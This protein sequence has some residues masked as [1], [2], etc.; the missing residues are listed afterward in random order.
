RFSKEF[1]EPGN[2]LDFTSALYLGL[3]H[4][5]WCLP[6]WKKLTLGKPAALQGPPGAREVERALSMLVGCDEVLL[7]PSTL[8]L[9]W[10][11]FGSLAQKGTAIF[12]DSGSY[13]IARWGVDRAAACGVPVHLFR[14]HDPGALRALLCSAPVKRP[15]VV[16]DGYCPVCA[17]AAPVADY[18][19]CVRALGGWVVLDDT[20]SLGIFG[21]ASEVLPYGRGGGGSLKRAGIRDS[22]LIIV[23]SL[24][25]AFGVPVAMLGGAQ[26]MIA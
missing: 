17:M 25:K 22:R 1:G 15:V 6:G 8:H 10:D 23:S 9:F 20:Q 7:A 26:D 11:L 3:E 21:E 14:R 24:A 4:A 19:E 5:S 18:L 2:V 12:L 13:P 16:A